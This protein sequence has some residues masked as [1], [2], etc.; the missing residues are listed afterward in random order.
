MET[1][2]IGSN[3]I[4]LDEVSSTNS[5]AIE[6]LKNVN[7][8]EGTLIFTNN[9]TQGKGQR[10]NKWNAEPQS[11]LT[12]SI[13]LK[14]SFLTSKNQFYLSKITALSCYDVM[15][16]FKE[17]SQFDIKIKWPNDIL[18]NQKKIGGVLIENTYSSEKINFSVIGIGLNINQINFAP[19]LNATSLKQLTNKEFDLNMVLQQLCKRLEVNYLKL[20]NGKFTEI[21]ANY[22]QKLFAINTW[23]TFEIEKE[24]KLLQ[25]KTVTEEGFLKLENKQGEVFNYELKEVKWVW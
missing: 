5:Y 14:P 17:A 19:E 21:D 8:A 23:R 1:L 4:F 11:N 3:T 18:V 24:L 12:A 16:E 6:L 10:G 2:F 7:L 20:R 22:L 13:V 15:A 9:Q 25:L